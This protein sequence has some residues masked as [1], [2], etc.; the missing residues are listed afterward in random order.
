MKPVFLATLTA[1]GLLWGC[2]RSEVG[3]A[4]VATAAPMAESV[5]PA[6]AETVSIPDAPLTPV[7][8]AR[9]CQFDPDLGKPNPLGMRSYIS[10]TEEDGHTTFLFEQFASRVGDGPVLVTLETNRRLT[11]YDTGVDRARQLML[12]N[13][14]YY[15][16][17]VGDGDPEGFG[18]VNEVLTCSP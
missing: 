7:E 2:A 11:F 12:E 15:S 17:L 10:I 3:Q 14:D 16:D 6:P 8:T 9:T 18:P 5:E 1:L 13:P 4:P